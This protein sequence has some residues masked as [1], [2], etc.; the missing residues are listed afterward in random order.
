M[1]PEAATP[2][3]VARTAGLLT[4]MGGLA[5]VALVLGTPGGLRDVHAAIAGSYWVGP[6]CGVLGF[7]RQGGD[8][9]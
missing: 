6:D 8:H 3:V 9:E 1:A 5:A 4:S 7:V 2:R